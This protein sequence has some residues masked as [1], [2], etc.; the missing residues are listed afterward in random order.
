M[1]LFEDAGGA[2]R[3]VTADD[4]CGEDRN[5]RFRV[6]L[7]KGHRYVLRFRL[8]FSDRPAETAVMMW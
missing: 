8:Y 4:D 7:V 2:L 5:A 1:V 3:Y 6:K